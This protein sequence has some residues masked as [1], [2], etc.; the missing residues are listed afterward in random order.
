MESAAIQGVR[1]AFSHA[2]ARAALGADVD[3][4]ETQTFD[5]LFEAVMSSRV[6]AGV[7]PLENTLA[8]AVQRTTDLLDVHAVHIVAEVR[9][10]IRLCLVTRPG[11]ALADVR[12]A[13]SHPVALQQCHDFFRRNPHVGAVAAFDT[14]GAVKDLLSGAAQYDAA[15]G[16]VLAAELYG[17]TILE[18]DLEDDA[19]NYTRF[20]IVRTA[21]APAP[22]A[23]A[24]T[25]L[26]FTLPHRPGA[27]HAAL[28]EIACLGVDLARIESRPI[29]GRP[30]EY[31]FH[32]D[33]RGT[34][35]AT[36][37]DAVRALDA[38]ASHVKV[39]GCY[40]EVV[41]EAD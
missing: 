19:G 9:L 36:Q 24:K 15:I 17:G 4:V 26:A 22:A 38:T 14:A 3:V 34:D 31:R 25:S 27:L 37:A 29:P 35:A 8:G 1:G 20:A 23:N 41:E 11:V 2:A 16:S 18:R 21:P 12:S 10:R 30:W 6:S 28:G 33:L 7:V 39:F 32:A 13:A 40:R 5:D